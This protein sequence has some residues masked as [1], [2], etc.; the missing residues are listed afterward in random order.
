MDIQRDMF[1]RSEYIL[2]YFLSPFIRLFVENLPI[3]MLLSFPFLLI[4]L[5]PF[6]PLD[7]IYQY[8]GVVGKW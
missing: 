4:R 8:M 6:G 7:W 3:Y 2:L 5:V 1:E